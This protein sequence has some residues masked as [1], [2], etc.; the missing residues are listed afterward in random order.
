MKSF[1][2]PGYVIT[3][4]SFFIEIRDKD[5]NKIV[6]TTGGMVYTTTPGAIQVKDWYASNRLVS[7]FSELTFA[8]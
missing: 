6:E 2:N 5:G 4:D 7:A 1:V 8:V 3:S